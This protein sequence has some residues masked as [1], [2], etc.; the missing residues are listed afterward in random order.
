MVRCAPALLLLSLAC[1]AW[2]PPAEAQNDWQF[3]DPYFGVLEFEKDH[4]PRP[5]VQRSDAPPRTIAP[6]PRGQR[7]RFFRPRPRAAVRPY[8]S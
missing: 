7:P 8:P 4:A 2:A 1:V 5:R 3:P 6:P